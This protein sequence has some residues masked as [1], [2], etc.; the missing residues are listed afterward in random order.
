MYRIGIDF[1]GSGIRVGVVDETGRMAASASAPT[2]AE[3]GPEQVLDDMAQC[4]INGLNFSGIELEECAGIGV[5]TP[6]TCDPGTGTVRN[7]HNLGWDSVPLCEMLRQR[8]DLPVCLANDADCAALG[9]AVYGAAKGCESALLITLGTGVGGGFVLGGRLCSGHRGLGGE[10]GHICIAMD[11]EACTCGQRGCWEAYASGSALIRQAEAAT[12]L[13]PAS[14]LNT[15]PLN[16][17]TIYAAAAAG[18]AAAREV[19]AKYAE[20]VGLGL[21]GLVN[22][23]FPQRVLLGGGIS[24]AGEALRAPVEAFVRAHAFVREPELLPEIGIASLGAEAGIF[25]AAA[26]V[27]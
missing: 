2:R 4:V 24:G 3:L 5:G 9:E 14:A 11:G 23:L 1:G 20:Y 19:T 16:G 25:G 27:P 6:G 22:A 8:L 17:K 26:L 13:H 21:T 12:K 10:F 15:A 18:D 7:L